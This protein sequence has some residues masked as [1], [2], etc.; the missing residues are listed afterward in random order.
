MKN[1]KPNVRYYYKVGDLKTNTYSELKYFKA[2]PKRNTTLN[3]IKIAIFGDMGTYVPFG[4]A[5]TKFIASNNMVNPYDFVFLTGDIAYAG[6]S[7]Q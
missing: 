4:H 1:L 5:V 3:E 7:H 2:P 6:I